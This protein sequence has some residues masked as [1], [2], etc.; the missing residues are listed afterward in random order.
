M[1]RSCFLILT[2]ALNLIA[3]KLPAVA[4]PPT[5]APGSPDELRQ[6]IQQL[7]QRLQDWAQLE[8]YRPANASLSPPTVSENRVVFFGDSITNF[9]N[10]AASFP[11]Q[12]YI[13]RGISGQTTPQMLLRFRSDVVAL[14]PRV[15]I[16]LGGTN[17]LAGNTGPMTLDQIEDNYA[18]MAELAKAHQIRVVFASL[19]PIHDYSATKVSDGRPLAKIES[20]NQWLKGYCTANHCLYL[21]YYSHMLDD[22]GMLRAELSD[23]GLHPN[24]NGYQIMARLA[25][26]AI[27]QVLRQPRL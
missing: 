19:L 1:Q 13:N 2:T 8:V 11:G 6:Q 22:R 20:L 3:L 10:L 26:R 25:A 17:D 14:K 23:D 9:W 15:V 12:P 7:Q 18:S 21:D 4:Q 5:A 24:A 27:Q 16:I